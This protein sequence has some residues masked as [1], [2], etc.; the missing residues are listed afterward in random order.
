MTGGRASR[1]KGNRTERAIVRLL[2]E[3]GLAAERVPLSGAVRGRF[4][5][6][7][8]VPV[9]GKDLRCE[10]KCRGGGFRR[11]YDWLDGADV[12]ILRADRRGLLVVVPIELAAEVAMA[13][14]RAKRRG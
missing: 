7:V 2:Q 9:L 11:L 3:R 4:G 1:D 10:V 14:E 5:G 13:A 12:L 8:S 6:D